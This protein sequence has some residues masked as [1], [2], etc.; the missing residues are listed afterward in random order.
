MQVG[1]SINQNNRNTISTGHL[2]V[3]ISLQSRQRKAIQFIRLHS[4]IQAHVQTT[5]QPRPDPTLAQEPPPNNVN[6]QTDL[7]LPRRNRR[8]HPSRSN[9]R[10]PCRTHLSGSRPRPVETTQ[11]SVDQRPPRVPP[12][13]PNNNPRRC[14]E[15]LGHTDHALPQRHHNNRNRLRVRRRQQTRP[16]KRTPSHPNHNRRRLTV[17][18]RHGGAGIHSLISRTRQRLYT[19]IRRRCFDDGYQ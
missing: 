1:I 15:P 6:H 10:P 13:Q 12:V 16:E 8:L 18:I 14:Q 2:L 5:L 4:S 17:R 3:K 19:T 9:P 7:R 11:S